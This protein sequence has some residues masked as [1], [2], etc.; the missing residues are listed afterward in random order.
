MRILILDN[1]DSFVYNLKVYIHELGYYNVLIKRNDD[2]SINE[3]ENFDCIVLSPGPGIPEEAGILKELIH[4]YAKQKPIFGVC[5]G[6]QAIGEVFGAQLVNLD[7]VYHGVQ[8]YIKVIEKA[9][10]F[11]NIENTQKVGRYH[12]WVVQNLKF[13][14]D[15]VITAVD[16]EGMIMAM[17]HK[18]YFI[19]SVQFHPESVMTPFGK[20]MLSNFLIAAEQQITSRT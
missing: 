11:E 17:K 8:T 9:R 5:L 1:Y 4:Q 7:R 10:I 20:K 3:I 13:P 18:K 2:I 19:E 16:E 14:S 15:L 6:H 12:S